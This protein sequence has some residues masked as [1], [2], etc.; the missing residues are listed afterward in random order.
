MISSASASGISIANSSSMAMTTSTAS[1]ESRPRSLVNEALFVSYKPR[2]VGG[3]VHIDRRFGENDEKI[4]VN[5][6][7]TTKKG[8]A[9]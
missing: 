7:M 5:Q 4:V 3:G 9:T 8:I 6:E 1:R 2:S